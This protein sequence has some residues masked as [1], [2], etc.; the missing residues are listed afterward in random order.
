MTT[1]YKNG[2]V[3]HQ[4]N[5]VEYRIEEE[6][7]CK[8]C[9]RDGNCRIADDYKKWLKVKGRHGLENLLCGYFALDESSVTNKEEY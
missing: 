7:L 9:V 6:N 3:K 5:G 2:F 8:Q 4:K 1:Y